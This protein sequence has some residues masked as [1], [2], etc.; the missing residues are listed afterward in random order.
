MLIT[1][2]SKGIGLHTAR[3]FAEEGCHIGLCA[4]NADDLRSAAEELRSKTGGRGVAAVQ[5]DVCDPGGA[6]R[7]VDG[8]VAELGGVDILVNNVGDS[9]GG[10]L[11]EGTDEDWE[12][13]FNINL[14]QTVRMTRLVVLHVPRGEAVRL[15]TS[16]P[17]P[18]GRATGGYG[19]VWLLEGARSSSSP[20]AS[21]WSWCE[22]RSG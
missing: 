16:P 3:A 11:M 10:N 18:G 4:R 13:T 5:A 21:R 17:Y 9:V 20:S 14:F 19:A 1:G 22:T 6:S 2:G 12:K 8:C 7:F 15:S